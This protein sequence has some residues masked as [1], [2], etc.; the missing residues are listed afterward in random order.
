MTDAR[1]RRDIALTVLVMVL[2]IPFA[3]AIIDGI[4]WVL[5]VWCVLLGIV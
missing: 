2:A 3:Q 4:V 5:T 1:L